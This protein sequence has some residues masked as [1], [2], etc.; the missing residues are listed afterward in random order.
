MKLI[1]RRGNKKLIFYFALT[2][3]FEG[4]LIVNSKTV[5]RLNA[6][7]QTDYKEQKVER[8]YICIL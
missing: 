4:S 2:L 5:A 1:S 6:F 3:S 8:Q 7:Y